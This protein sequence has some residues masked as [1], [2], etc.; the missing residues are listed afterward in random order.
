MNCQ[1]PIHTHSAHL[2]VRL[3]IADGKATVVDV[4]IASQMATSMCAAVG[5]ENYAEL[6]SVH[7]SETFAKAYASV[8]SCLQDSEAFRWCMPFIEATE[9]RERARSWARSKI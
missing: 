9:R 7:G 8:K 2:L 4:I 3:A 1:P 5:R 6:F